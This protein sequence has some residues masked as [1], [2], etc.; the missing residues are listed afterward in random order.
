MSSSALNIARR[1]TAIS[2]RLLLLSVV[3]VIL[4]G[5]LMA[6]GFPAFRD[7]MMQL[8]KLAPRFVRKA[9]E[10][11]T[12]GL[13]F[14]GYVGMA[15]V[16]PV[17]LV[18]MAA[19][20]IVRSVRAVA[21]DLERG[22]LGWMLAYPI[23][24][25]PFLL[26]RASVMFAGVVVLHIA[27][28]L[29]LRGWGAFYQVELGPWGPYIQAGVGGCLLYG[30]VGAMTL[31]VSAGSLR[32]SV[33]ATFGAGLL[34]ASLVFEYGGAAW[35]MIEPLRWVSLFHY[36]DAR[37]IM[38]GQLMTSRDVLVLSSLLVVSLVGACATFAR[39]DLPI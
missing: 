7:R 28:V 26:A 27:L 31:W 21:G 30:A 35:E 25:V 12:G 36:Y 39:R 6:W 4:V 24:R 18:L 2:W 32:A 15:F 23:G 3:A 1:D 9:M 33:P 17:T 5:Y 34:L 22:A 29:S 20:P 13:T 19:W 11:R 14:E 8:G 37:A 10:A 16:H 38:K